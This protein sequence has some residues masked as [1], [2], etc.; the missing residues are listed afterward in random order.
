MG[1]RNVALGY[2]L[3]APPPLWLLNAVRDVEET[4]VDLFR[5]EVALEGAGLANVNLDT[6]RPDLEERGYGGFRRALSLLE[7]LGGRLPALP[8]PAAPTTPLPGR[9]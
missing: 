5:E 6:G 1:G 9:A 7:R 4:F 8:A 2:V 3:P